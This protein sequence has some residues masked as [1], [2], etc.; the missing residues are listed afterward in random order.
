MAESAVTAVVGN[1]GRLA[2]QETTFLC[3]VT[4]LKDELMRLQG[5]LK[6]AD[7]KRRSGNAAVAILV[8]QIRDAAYV[9]ENVIE[10]VEHMQK[11]NRLRKGFVG[12]VSR[13][14]RLPANLVNLHQVGV[15]VKRVRRKF[16]E[17]FESAHR[18]K[19]D[20]DTN[21]VEKCHDED[22]FP[23]DYC[24]MHQNFEDDIVMVGF[25]DEYKEIVDKLVHGE[26]MLSA[27]SIVAMGGAGKTTLAR[28]VCTSS[29][30]K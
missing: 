24:L 18:L 2:I 23:Q 14:A 25:Q 11:S 1:V 8:V 17:I 15:Q 5:Y 29:R 9:A 26:N 19:I 16:S 30:V 21:A 28:R 20:L 27:V 4:F 7:V 13:Y 3:G 12:A 22:E 6:D 10:A